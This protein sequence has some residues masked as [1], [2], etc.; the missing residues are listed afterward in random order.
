MAYGK[1]IPPDQQQKVTRE[2]SMYAGALAALLATAR[3]QGTGAPLAPPTPLSSPQ[4]GV[5]GLPLLPQAT[6]GMGAVGAVAGPPSG[7]PPGGPEMALSA[8]Q[9]PGAPSAMAPP[10]A[11]PA[12]LPAGTPMPAPQMLARGGAVQPEMPLAPGP[13]PEMLHPQLQAPH[14]AV[15]QAMPPGNLLFQHDPGAP[16]GGTGTPQAPGPDQIMPGVVPSHSLVDMV[17]AHIH[18]GQGTA[19]GQGGQD[20]GTG[21]MVG[22]G[23]D[24]IADAGPPPDAFVNWV[25]QTKKTNTEMGDALIEIGKQ[26]DGVQTAW[27]LANELYAEDPKELP[28]VVNRMIRSAERTSPTTEMAG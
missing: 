13:A 25:T 10:P 21:D 3:E 12:G 19:G 14:S 15:E 22:E 17:L 2:Q 7:M 23:A 16:A 24:D 20:E 26:Q 11:P 6:A 18:G 1:F 28:S 27:N 5:G 4:S 9:I 8:P